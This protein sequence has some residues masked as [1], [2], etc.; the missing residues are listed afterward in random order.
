[1]LALIGSLGTSAAIAA[2]GLWCFGCFLLC[3]SSYGGQVGICEAAQQPAPIP[4]SEIIAL[5]KELASPGDST[6]ATRRTMKNTA[7]KARALLQEAPEAPNRFAVL[8]IMLMA[9]KTL[10]AQSN[11]ERNGE[12][13][14]ATCEELAKAPDESGTVP[15]G[16]RAEG[17]GARS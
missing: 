3:S 7:R 11:T 6:V 13:L 16:Y 15:A 8:G 17:S 10:L 14:F 4:E 1:V 12:A 5:Q 9:Q 2:L